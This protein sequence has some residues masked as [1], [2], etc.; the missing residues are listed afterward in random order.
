MPFSVSVGTWQEYTFAVAED[1]V[2]IIAHD[3]AVMTLSKDEWLTVV[4]AMA[5]VYCGE[6]LDQ[7]A[8]RMESQ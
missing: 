2:R 7:H 3:T 8:K 5:A 4:R 6:L 1:T